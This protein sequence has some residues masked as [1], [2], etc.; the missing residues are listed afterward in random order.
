MRCNHGFERV[1]TSPL[2]VLVTMTNFLSDQI[3]AHDRQIDD[4]CC[5]SNYFR[6]WVLHNHTVAAKIIA[7]NGVIHDI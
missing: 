1:A 4:N 7:S 2:R 5:D 3:D 6:N